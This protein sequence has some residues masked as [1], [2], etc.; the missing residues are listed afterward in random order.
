[1]PGVGAA[2]LMHFNAIHAA[3]NGDETGVISAVTSG[4]GAMSGAIIGTC[5]CP[6]LGT[7]IGGF[8]GS[9]LGALGGYGAG[10]LIK[11]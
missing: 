7:A 11:K 8:I 10:K 4:Y 2:V 3:M 6:G 5:I 9:A 1:M